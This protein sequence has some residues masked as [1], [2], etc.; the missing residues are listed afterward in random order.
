MYE[1][2]TVEIVKL[3]EDVQV[4]TYATD[5]SSGFDIYA[6]EDVTIFPGQT[7]I[8]KTGFK[9]NIPEG[10]EVQIRSRSGMSI[11]TPLRIAPG[12]GTIDSDF[13]EEVGI[14]FHNQ[15]E[16][17]QYSIKKGERIAQG[18]LCPVYRANL[19]VVPTFTLYKKTARAGGF[20]STG[21]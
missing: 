18:V 11:K 3:R 2:R 8:V 14:I 17:T 4:P 6:P 12:I 19:L 16:Q 10:A 13:K 20:G 1:Y 21:K 5:G 7:I 9:L 15:S